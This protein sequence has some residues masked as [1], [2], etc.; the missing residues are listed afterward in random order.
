[1]Q[2]LLSGLAM[3]FASGLA[4]GPLLVVVVAATLRGGFRHGVL[5]GIAPL[6]TDL[7][8]IVI[9]LFVLSRLP[10]TATSA[11]GYLGAAV[12]LWYAFEV[13]RDARRS[14]L[15]ELRS[16]AITA[17][18]AAKSLGQGVLANAM[19]P[20]PWMFWMTAGGAILETAWR[21]SPWQVLAFLVPFYVLLVGS[22]VALAWALDAGSARLSDRTYRGLLYLA[23]AMLVYLAFTLA[24][25]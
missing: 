11:I 12:L 8:I 22:K 13:V 1:M 10:A 6:I 19:N 23:A 3:G 2:F 20:A 18:P 5:A 7:P 24:R 9:S 21:V 4:P 25:A 16:G 14:S 15:S 17:A